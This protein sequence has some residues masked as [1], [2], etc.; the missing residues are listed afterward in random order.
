MTLLRLV[1]TGLLLGWGIPLAHADLGTSPVPDQ[2]AR[3][4][5]IESFRNAVKAGDL[6]PFKRHVLSRYTEGT[7]ERLLRSGDVEARRAA[8]AA[9]SLVGTMACNPALAAAQAD[10]DPTIRALAAEA[11]WEVWFRAGSPEQN[12]TLQDI[13]ELIAE[14]R[15][16]QAVA[17]ATSLIQENPHFAEAYNQRAI[18][19][20]IQGR[21]ADSA[22]DCRAAL[23]RNPFHFGALGGLTQC[24][25]RMNQKADALAALRKLQQLQPRNL[26]LRQSIAILEAEARADAASGP[27]DNPE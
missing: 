24:C 25:L 17:K 5:L 8:A 13:R 20:F 2:P 14:R 27:G 22:A 11:S 6:E 23:E 21:Y 16:D 4:L 26:E 1:S 12:Q 15:I 9:L 7:L 10:E 18:A 3:A 19:R